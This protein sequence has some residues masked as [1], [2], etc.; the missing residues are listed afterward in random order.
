[1]VS[2]Q[3]AQRGGLLP[4]GLQHHH[5]LSPAQG[6]APGSLPSLPALTPPNP[7][8]PQGAGAKP[9]ECP[10]PGFPCLS[11]GDEDCDRGTHQEPGDMGEA[12]LPLAGRDGEG[13]PKERGLMWAT[14]CC[15]R[16]QS[17][18]GIQ[19]EGPGDKGT[20]GEA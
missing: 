14:A 17:G 20:H 16:G 3:Q 2:A 15:V 8:R 7:C 6:T 11:L 12:G 18:S 5:A 13:L 9:W 4:H 10:K 1:M 19:E